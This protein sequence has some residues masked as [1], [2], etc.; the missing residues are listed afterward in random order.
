MWKYHVVVWGTSL[1]VTAVRTAWATAKIDSVCAPSD[2]SGT[3]DLCNLMCGYYKNKNGSKEKGWWCFSIIFPQLVILVSTV[4]MLGCHLRH[5]WIH[6]THVGWTGIM[7]YWLAEA[8]EKYFVLVLG[9]AWTPYIAWNFWFLFSDKVSDLNPGLL[10][11]FTVAAAS[12]GIMAT[13]VYFIHACSRDSQTRHGGNAWTT[14]GL[15]AHVR[16]EQPNLCDG[17][18][19]EWRCEEEA[20]LRKE[21]QIR[22]AQLFPAIADAFDTANSGTFDVEPV[23][24]TW[25]CQATNFLASDPEYELELLLTDQ[26]TLLGILL[27]W[28]KRKKDITSRIA[29]PRA[30][31]RS[32]PISG[33]ETVSD[34]ESRDSSTF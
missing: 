30:T 33:L 2:S 31:P 29:T 12:V 16:F 8:A 1:V 17:N 27:E 10:R 22:A 28:A 14:D 4:A 15:L 6:S 23:P 26:T 25:K 18:G 34:D 24:F 20:R 13:I 19:S 7:R 11:F 9:C 5:R 3:A 32:T 21:F